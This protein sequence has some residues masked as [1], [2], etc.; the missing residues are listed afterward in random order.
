MI[1]SPIHLETGNFAQCS[2]I[3]MLEWLWPLWRIIITQLPWSHSSQN[4]RIISHGAS[5]F[6]LWVSPESFDSDAF[7]PF[8]SF[9]N[10]N[11]AWSLGCNSL[12]WCISW[13]DGDRSMLIIQQPLRMH[14]SNGD[15]NCNS[16]H[17]VPPAAARKYKTTPTYAA[18]EGVMQTFELYNHNV[19]RG[20]VKKK[21]SICGV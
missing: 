10:K 8:F 1:L 16:K 12:H 17:R 18:R 15:L 3:T 9:R 5:F 7:S 11:C 13:E 14:V 2:H 4:K 6:Q 19:D 20:T 21:D